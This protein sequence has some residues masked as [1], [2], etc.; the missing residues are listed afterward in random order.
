MGK[1]RLIGFRELVVLVYVFVLPM[2][3]L[4]V[5][6][7]VL[8]DVVL[9]CFD[10]LETFHVEFFFVKFDFRI[11]YYICGKNEFLFDI[12]VL[13][14]LFYLCCFL[15]VFVFP[16]LYLFFVVFMIFFP[17]HFVIIFIF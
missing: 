4:F 3:Y 1:V 10:V 15:Y 5:L 13:L 2:V 7:L 14:L 11:T 12:F 6:V 8:V 9:N 16:F 17:I